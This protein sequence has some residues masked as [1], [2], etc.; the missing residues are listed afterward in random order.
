[1]ADI[2]KII[3]DLNWIYSAL[4]KGV[5]IENDDAVIKSIPDAISLLKEHEA[6]AGDWIAIWRE[7][8]PD[9]ST[10]ARCSVCGRVSKRP[11]GEYCKWCGAKMDGRIG[12]VYGENTANFPK[13][14]IN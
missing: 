10:S 9:T 2:E 12:D 14:P 1:M 7:D 4:F 3:N 13:M 11:C 8:D 5:I 6:K